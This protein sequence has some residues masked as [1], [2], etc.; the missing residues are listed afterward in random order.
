MK[1]LLHS[2]RTARWH[3]LLPA[4]LL[5]F[6]LAACADDEPDP[7]MDEDAMEA[8]H[9]DADA[10][11]K[12]A[13]DAMH[14]E[15][16]GMHDAARGAH[17]ENGVQVVEVEVIKEGYRP[18][19]ITLEA[20]VPARLVFTRRVEGECPSQV[21]IPAFGIE[22]TDLPMN[23]PVALEFTPDERGTF[24]FAC[25]MDMLKGTVVVES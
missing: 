9:E 4:L 22:A 2:D 5:A 7:M 19:R 20:G 3:R 15:D 12:D 11:H 13:A 10:M 21:R 14:D 17:M 23:E 18:E 24:T 1:T 6:T 8:M 25:G 16:A